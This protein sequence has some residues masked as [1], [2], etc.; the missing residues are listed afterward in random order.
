MKAEVLRVPEELDKDTCELV[1]GEIVEALGKIVTKGDRFVINDT[2]WY[3][4]NG[5]KATPTA[6]NSAKYI[7]R[8]VAKQIKSLGWTTEMTLAE[9]TIDGYK[10]FEVH[11]AGYTLSKDST[12]SLVR[13]SWEGDSY[14]PNLM[15]NLYELHYKRS[16]FQ[17]SRESQ[18][19]IDLFRKANEA[20]RLRVGLE[21]ETGNIAS[22]FRALSKLDTLFRENFLDVGVFVTSLDKSSTATRIW[23]A[24]NR[25][26][27]FEELLARSFRGNVLLPLIEVAFSPD[28][29]R[30]DARYL[31]KDGSTYEPN[32]TGEMRTFQGKKYAVFNDS[33]GLEI[34]KPL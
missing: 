30:S 9:Q 8:G 34:L 29:I 11:K 5:K 6:V 32:P 26:G 13:E 17:P 1:A 3:K 22:S 19:N 31:A 4:N 2:L 18:R 28:E 23:P 16:V 24:S 7:T 21:F 25:N 15:A 20:G 33:D 10:E 27:S 14:P 12:L